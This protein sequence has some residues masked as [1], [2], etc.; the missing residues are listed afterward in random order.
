VRTQVRARS[1]FGLFAL[2]LG[3]LVSGLI[4]A[5]GALASGGSHSGSTVPRGMARVHIVATRQSAPRGLAAIK[6]TY[7][8]GKV[9]RSKSTTY[10]I[11]WEPTTLQD[12]S[13]TSVSGTY[14]SLLLRYFGD[15]GGSKLYGN[16][17]Q[18]YQKNGT[19]KGHIVNSSSLG[20][21]WVDTSAYPASGCTDPVTPGN[22]LSDAQ[23]QAEVQAAMTA[24]GWTG[25]RNHLFLVFTSKGEGS[26][27]GTDCA[28]TAF[29]AYH[30]SFESGAGLVLYANQPYTGTDLG[31]CGVP[32]S[33]NGDADA[34]STINV[35]SH[36]HI[37]AVTDPQG[38]AWYDANGWEIGDKCAW[39]F[40]TTTQDG[41]L[42][43]QSMHG[44]FYILQ[45]EWD[46]AKS[47]CVR[48]G[49]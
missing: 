42:A 41:G 31:A 13:A 45:T 38:N 1:R 8:G 14:N 16:N 48:S 12:T 46:N 21:S 49:P 9:M 19:A 3:A 34:D 27:A 6:M 11:F 35:T 22:C 10:A 47:A 30:S 44:H 40:G 32:S 20:G 23:L 39:M 15:I 24:N 17:T 37:E 25:G 43:N 28:F 2:I 4:P 33:P 36:E 18:Y 26:C 5:A 29:C 7:H